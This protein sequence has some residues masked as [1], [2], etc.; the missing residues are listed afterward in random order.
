VKQWA[1]I[2]SPKRWIEFL[3]YRIRRSRLHRRNIPRR[4]LSPGELLRQ[5]LSYYEQKD[6]PKIDTAFIADFSKARDEVLG[7]IKKQTAFTLIVFVFLASN[8]LGSGLS[9]S[10][11]GISLKESPGVAEGLLLAA[12]LLA[13]YTLILQGNV[14]L[15]DNAVRASRPADDENRS[16]SRFATLTC[17]LVAV[18]VIYPLIIAVNESAVGRISGLSRNSCASCDWAQRST[19]RRTRNSPWP[20]L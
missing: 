13:C 18:S 14:Y 2:I 8:Y 19:R 17:L 12:N 15:L 10:I 1:I 3:Q 6:G 7:L 4:W 20:F 11:L 9:F 5:D 16:I